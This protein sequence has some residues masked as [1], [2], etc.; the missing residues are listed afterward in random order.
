M[1]RMRVFFDRAGAWAIILTR[2][3][4]YSVPEVIVCLAGLGGMR[5]GEFLLAMTLGSLPTAFVYAA[6][7]AGWSD[8]PL[9]ALAMS[10]VLPIVT[11]P[12]ALYLMRTR[13]PAGDEP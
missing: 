6:I 8:Q 4:P 10:Y 13:R 5:L 2:S 9:L 7:G 12:L 11:L 1:E 3:L